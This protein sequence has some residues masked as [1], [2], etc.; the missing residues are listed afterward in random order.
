MATCWI[1]LVA[2]STSSMVMQPTDE[3]KRL[4]ERWQ[5][6]Q[7]QQ[8][9]VGNKPLM[10]NTAGSEGMEGATTSAVPTLTT[11]ESSS[12][13]QLS[14]ADSRLADQCL[15]GVHIVW[16]PS[17]SLSS[18]EISNCLQASSAST[19]PVDGPD[20]RASDDSRCTVDTLQRCCAG[21]GVGEILP[22]INKYVV[23]PD[24]IHHYAMFT[25]TIK[26]TTK[27]LCNIVL[28]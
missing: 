5:Q 13:L 12:P 14:S 21:Y 18:S 16:N 22:S 24:T 20:A 2:G 1:A 7:Q 27:H 26:L 28:C 17:V 15:A 4:L 8:Q 25:S 10:F 9:G 11:V 19:Q 3:D 6:M 23:S